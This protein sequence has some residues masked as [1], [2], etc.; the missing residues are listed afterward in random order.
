MLYAKYENIPKDDIV[1]ELIQQRNITQQLYSV[2]VRGM[3]V[4]KNLTR[5]GA[6]GAT[7]FWIGH[8]EAYLLAG[9]I[10]VIATWQ[11]VIDKTRKI[12]NPT[13]KLSEWNIL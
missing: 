6:V 7:W 8:K 1:S 3:V 2:I 13:L 4:L 11:L 12:V 9:F 5:I 10:A